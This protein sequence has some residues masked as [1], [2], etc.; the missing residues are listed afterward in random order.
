MAT[1][2]PLAGYNTAGYIDGVQ[3]AL[4]EW[5]ITPEVDDLDA[6]STESGGFHVAFP[7]VL[8]GEITLTGFYDANNNPFMIG[9]ASA[10]G[11]EGLMPGNYV[12]LQIY[13]NANPLVGSEPYW[14]FPTVGGNPIS[15]AM[16]KSCKTGMKINEKVMFTAQLI[17][18][19]TFT[20]P[21]L[22]V[23]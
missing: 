9:P 17:G 12:Q 13:L 21:N 7:G 16:V 1:A 8:K 6:T 23:G 4:T 5:E 11:L 3:V 20:Y 10:T 22:Q 19:G 18:S 14:N 2:I 15:G